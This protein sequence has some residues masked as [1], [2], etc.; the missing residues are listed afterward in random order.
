[1][2]IMVRQLFEATDEEE[3]KLALFGFPNGSGDHSE[4]IQ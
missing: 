2:T 3:G 1:M 4:T